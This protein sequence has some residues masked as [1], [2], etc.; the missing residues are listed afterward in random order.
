[1]LF[2]H[3][4]KY[5]TSGQKTRTRRLVREGDYAVVDETDPNRPILQVISTADAGVPKP[6]YEVGKTYSVQPGLAK[7]TMGNIRITAIRRERLQ[8][9]TEAE[10]LKELPLTSLEEGASDAQWA[11]KIFMGTWNIMNSD[12]GE[13]WEDNPEVWVLEFE[14]ALKLAPKKWTRFSRSNL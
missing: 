3:T 7:K 14:P 9:L 10:A 4:W 11:L 5:V 8:D 6:L 1:M 2:E 12:P 13:R